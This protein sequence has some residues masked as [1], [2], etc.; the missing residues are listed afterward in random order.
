MQYGDEQCRNVESTTAT[1]VAVAAKSI[2]TPGPPAPPSI[3][4]ERNETAFEEATLMKARAP[5]GTTARLLITM[6][7]DPVTVIPEML[8]P[9]SPA[10]V[11][12]AAGPPRPLIATEP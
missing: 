7:C 2:A 10:S 5:A 6:R 1:P 12:S 9:A 3:C 4:S 8:A 11:R